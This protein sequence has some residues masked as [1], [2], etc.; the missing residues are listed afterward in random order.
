V[1]ITHFNTYTGATEVRLDNLEN[2]IAS[3][4]TE[5]GNG[6]TKTAAQLT[7]TSNISELETTRTGCI[8]SMSKPDQEVF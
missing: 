8:A 5:A 2:S 4:V 1:S 7:T 3:G 6:L